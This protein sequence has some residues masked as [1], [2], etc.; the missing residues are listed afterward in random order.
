MSPLLDSPGVSC[1]LC[2][3]VSQISPDSD[4]DAR[5]ESL[6]AF[7]EE[8]IFAFKTR[9]RT[10][11]APYW[12]MGFENPA[13]SNSQNGLNESLLANCNKQ[14]YRNA[15]GL[16]VAT[17]EVISIARLEIPAKPPL[18]PR[19][20]HEI[21]NALCPNGIC[22]IAS[23]SRMR[24]LRA[25]SK[26]EFRGL[27]QR[28]GFLE[29]EVGIPFRLT[30][31]EEGC[32]SPFDFQP[33]FDWGHFNSDIGAVTGSAVVQRPLSS[34]ADL[35]NGLWLFFFDLAKSFP[36]AQQ[37]CNQS[38]RCNSLQPLASNHYLRKSV[39]QRILCTHSKFLQH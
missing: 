31:T 11:I 35:D 9:H 8:S 10:L 4:L 15:H 23:T 21:E 6:V 37:S 20:I 13:S 29:D 39:P 30:M 27:G 22:A 7:P 32:H 25:N 36:C 12:E 17:P 16:V 34:A 24:P 1:V 19:P 28:I 2:S 3:M 33:L 38:Q 5:Q 14:P 18:R 26:H